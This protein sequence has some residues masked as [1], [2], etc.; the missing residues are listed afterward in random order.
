MQSDSDD[1]IARACNFLLDEK[2]GLAVEKYSE[3]FD[4]LRSNS[5]KI[6]A[7]CISQRAFCYEKLGEHAKELEDA[8]EI[9]LLEPKNPKGYILAARALFALKNFGS[10]ADYYTFALKFSQDKAGLSQYAF[11]SVKST[12]SSFRGS[13]LNKRSYSSLSL[14]NTRKWLNHDFLRIFPQ[15][16]AET[17]FQHIPTVSLLKLR[18]VSR[19]WKYFID[20]S[21]RIWHTIDFHGVPESKPITIYVL[22]KMIRSYGLFMTDS[23]N[24][25]KVAP[26]HVDLCLSEII[27]YN[28]LLESYSQSSNLIEIS[29]NLRELELDC[30]P[31]LFWNKNWK[32]DLKQ[33][34]VNLVRLRIVSDDLIQVITIMSRHE[35]SNLKVLEITRLSEKQSNGNIYFPATLTR[36]GNSWCPNLKILKLEGAIPDSHYG[37]PPDQYVSPIPE[38]RYL[39][40][41]CLSLIKLLQMVPTLESFTMNCVEVTPL[42]S[43]PLREGVLNF[44][45]H[46]KLEVL[47]LYYC[48]IEHMPIVTKSCK[49]ITLYQTK[50]LPRSL[51]SGN[52]DTDVEE[53]YYNLESLDLSYNKLIRNGKLVD[54]LYRCNGR[55]LTRL[56]IQFCQKLRLSRFSTS[57]CSAPGKSL[58]EQIVNLCPEL[59]ILNIRGNFGITSESTLIEFSKLKF[60]ELLDVSETAVT[61]SMIV[62]FLN[63]YLSD[64]A[65]GILRLT[66][67]DG[68]GVPSN[69]ASRMVSA[70]LTSALSINNPSKLVNMKEFSIGHSVVNELKIPLNKLVVERCTGISFDAVLWL[71]SLGIDVYH[72]FIDR[73]GLI[74]RKRQ[75]TVP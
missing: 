4:I 19:K 21:R 43:N 58:A 35:Y 15:E 42:K 29:Q 70:T 68:N 5:D 34:I 36:G 40:I 25:C 1:L 56:N 75:K 71:E 54:S 66:C 26:E 37:I 18:R 64:P 12:L 62:A 2:Y 23:I 46:I 53:E 63:G 17:I 32:S 41:S 8:K 30:R 61:D 20:S 48:I 10:A 74:R 11:D 44:K 52:P 7:E 47:G 33:L 65:C 39:K 73:N 72:S 13:Q 45:D 31:K 6:P 27:H 24:L 22:Q 28:S 9:I 69:L 60:L 57:K 16:I 49:S 67:S 3:A 55:R 51:R 50:T 14:A 38:S 59:R